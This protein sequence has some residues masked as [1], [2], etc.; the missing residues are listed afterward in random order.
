MRL[1]RSDV[2]VDETGAVEVTSHVSHQDA[3]QDVT[4]GCHSRMPQ[5]DATAG[6]H[7]RMS[8]Q[9]V[10]RNV[11]ARCHSS[12]SQHPVTAACHNSIAAQGHNKMSQ[13]G[14]PVSHNKMPGRMSRQEVG[15]VSNDKIQDVK[16]ISWQHEGSNGEA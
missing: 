7:G 4:A 15:A 13:S 16:C 5:E 6:C 11:T 8:Q 12:Q 2:D 10:R 9:D 1:L 3:W 14:K